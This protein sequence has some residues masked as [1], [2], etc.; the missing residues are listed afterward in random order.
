MSLYIF[1]WKGGATNQGEGSSPADAFTHLGFG[2]E[3]MPALDYY[4]E[5]QTDGGNARENHRW[6][7]PEHPN[8]GEPYSS[9]GREKR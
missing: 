2:A 8:D 9:I 7:D 5:R 3:A 4:E 6:A 1:H